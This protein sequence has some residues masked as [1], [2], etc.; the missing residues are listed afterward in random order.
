M[1]RSLVDAEKLKTLLA[2]QPK[3][4]D[5]DNATPFVFRG[6][7][8]LFEDVCFSYDG[9][10]QATENVSFC[11]APGE[12][13]AF[14]GETGG[15]KS[16]IFKLLFR[17]FDPGKGRILID[18]QDLKTI[19]LITFRDYVGIVPQDPLLFH[20][21]IADNLKYPDLDATQEEIEEAC[22]AVALHDK[23][24]SFRKGYEQ[25]V[26]A[27]GTKLSGGELQRVAIARAILKNP[28][29]LLLDEATSSVDA[30]C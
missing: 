16:T 3:I 21:S 10:R 15:G 19:E 5:A 12:T 29:I 11:I 13:V 25:K 30:V 17:F 4:V 14:V 9:N 23:I 24:M 7:K 1:A 28:K 26:G 20:M 8:V 2:K 18:D 27:R 22:K 6:G